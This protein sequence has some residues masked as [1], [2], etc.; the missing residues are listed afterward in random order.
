M[1][2]PTTSIGSPIPLSGSAS[3]YGVTGADRDIA[4]RALKLLS[5][6][7]NPRILGA[8]T[9]QLESIVHGQPLQWRDQGATEVRRPRELGS[10]REEPL[11]R[12]PEAEEETAEGMSKCEAALV[13]LHDARVALAKAED[14]T[15]SE[16]ARA[17]EALREAERAAAHEAQMQRSLGYRK[18]QMHRSGV[19][20]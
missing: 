2:L 1:G 11:G 6:V 13:Q 16:R 10:E 8:A 3:D 20:A 5:G 19:A 4:A 15:P 18:S 14:V 7:S 17:E 9:S 12:K